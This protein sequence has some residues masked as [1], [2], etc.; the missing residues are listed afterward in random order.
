LAVNGGSDKRDPD[1]PASTL[2]RAALPA[3][4]KMQLPGMIINGTVRRSAEHERCDLQPRC[5]ARW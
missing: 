5:W 2:S 1:D 3:P 4:N